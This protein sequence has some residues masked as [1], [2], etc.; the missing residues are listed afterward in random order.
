M[1]RGKVVWMNAHTTANPSCEIPSY[2][3]EAI[4][5]GPVPVL[6]DFTMIPN[7]KL[8]NGEKI[9]RWAEHSLI[10]PEGPKV[11][12]QLMLDVYQRVFI[13][14]VFDNPH[15]TSK[16]VLSIARRNGKTFLVAVIL[17]AFII[18]PMRSLNTSMCSGANAQN[19]ARVAF[20]LMKLML[21]MSPH[22]EEGVHYTYTE[23]GG[24]ITGLKSNVRYRAI[25][26][27][28]KTGHGKAYKIILLDEAGQI[29][30]ESTDFT[31]ML[32]TSMS[33]YD[34]ALFLLISTQAPS[35]SAY[36]SQQIDHASIEQDPCIVSHVYCADDGCDLLDEAQWQKAN[37]GLGKFV[38]LKKMRQKAEEARQLPSK[39]N[40]IMNLNFNMRVSL[41]ALLLSPEAWK[42]NQREPNMITRKTS[43]IHF[44][45]D[46]STKSDLTAV[47]ASWR[48]E[49]GDINVETN[50][51]APLIGV[52]IREL[53]DKAPYQRWAKEGYLHL[54]PTP[55]VEFEW[56]AEF[57][58]KKY[59]GC[60]IASVQ[61]D[62]YKM[63]LF[64]EAAKKTD[65]YTMVPGTDK[66]RNLGWIE[67]GQGFVGMGIRVDSF[68]K[69]ILNGNLRTGKH[70]VLNL[71]ASHAIISEDPAGNRK[72]MKNKS[73]QKI[74][75]IVAAL[76][77]VHP[78]S[79]GQVKQ[80]PFDVE[81]LIG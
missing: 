53:R 26:A 15:V 9:I 78:N 35:D 10:V 31:D 70:P 11:G 14:S 59:A 37:P 56:V 19:Q 76:M 47:V 45:F 52:E 38:S 61:F 65:F 24:K 18:G 21:D 68:E 12:E 57:L 30:A 80:Q 4:R 71:A 55:T 67:V 54:T 32:E 74:D 43:P 50:A 75:P 39:A 22:I 48:D 17:L 58:A 20:D 29:A 40:G 63:N 23:S 13:L 66:D 41:L 1:Q 28:A 36:L 3:T 7:D 5:S 51:F 77:S 6:R 79:D 69:E 62:R 42:K 44:G 8:T 33:N 2:V 81:A 34:D 25:S 72:P 16:A 49:N 60:E 46:L 64:I 27:D 73:T